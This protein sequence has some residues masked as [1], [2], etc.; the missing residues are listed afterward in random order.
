MTGRVSS[1]PSYN[2]RLLHLR[3]SP[4]VPFGN[5]AVR[6]R[7]HR[8]RRPNGS[9][10]LTIR[11]RRLPPGGTRKGRNPRGSG[12][13]VLNPPDLRPTV[14]GVSCIAPTRTGRIRAV[15]RNDAGDTGMDQ[16]DEQVRL[17]GE[18]GTLL[19]HDTYKVDLSDADLCDL[20]R[21][22]V[23]VRR[24]DVEGN[25][26]QRQG[27]LGIRAPCLGQEAAQ[28]GSARA[29]RPDDFVFPSYREHGVVYVRAGMEVL[30]V[31]GLYRGAN[32]SGWDPQRHKLAQYSI[33]I[34]TQ[35][36]HAVGYA[37]GAKWDGAEVCA[38]AYFG[39]GATSEGDVSEA[40]NFAA[41]HSAPV[42]FF[43]QNNQWAISVPLAKQMAGPVYKR[44]LGFGFPG[45]QVDGNDVLAVYAVTRAPADPDRGH[46]LPA[47]GPH[48]HR[49]PD[50]LPD[51]RRARHVE[52]PG[53]DRPLPG[54]PGTGRA[55]VRGAGARRP[56]RGR[57]GG[58]RGPLD[59]R[60]HARPAPVRPGRPRLRRPAG[61]PPGPVAAARG[62]RGP[63]PGRGLR[64]LRW[65]RSRWPGRS[66]RPCATPWM[67]TTGWCC[68]ARTSAPSAGSSA[69][70]TGC[71]R[72]SASSG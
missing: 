2:R 13:C 60:E 51:L 23:V 62:V 67:P 14:P 48:H 41:V 24:I 22:L 26:L 63:V 59:G 30:S 46:H 36:L 33:P 47:R 34:G 32:L 44:A 52:G 29:L 19:Q 15:G 17:L 39:D 45:V 27:Q 42:V 71:S 38:V 57:P 31:L 58:G 20:Y 18:D 55:L 12:P 6:S 28:V 11:K 25:N 10:P 53:A 49:R 9:G 40:F 61:D 37:I 54:V 3:S 56:G 70:P 7:C 66:M 1:S 64:R 21:Q 50:P 43:C 4:D 16:T 35:A 72:T 65:R 5:S 68:W 69:S 8:R